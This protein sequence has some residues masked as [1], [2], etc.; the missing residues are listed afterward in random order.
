MK[1]I[2]CGMPSGGS[3]MVYSTLRD[4]FLI[5]DGKK[6]HRNK[7]YG[8]DSGGKSNT[9]NYLYEPEQFF[10]GESWTKLPRGR[11]SKQFETFDEEG[12]ASLPFEH[13]YFDHIINEYENTWELPEQFW[14]ILNSDNFIM[15]QN[16]LTRIL[17][18]LTLPNEIELIFIVRAPLQWSYSV[19]RFVGDIRNHNSCFW[20]SRESNSMGTDNIEQTIDLWIDIAYD[21]IKLCNRRRK[22]L[23]LDY[24][25][26]NNN[27]DNFKQKMDNFYDVD[28]NW[29]NYVDA[30]VKR[31]KTGK[32]QRIQDIPPQVFRYKQYRSQEILHLMESLGY[33]QTQIDLYNKAI[34]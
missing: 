30:P 18:V 21:I 28:M 31:G 26:L 15:K 8:A 25:E 13:L 17:P 32:N 11:Y 5:A 14:N 20:L 9:F 4:S 29:Y 7:A 34:I 22:T 19:S 2:V 12:S 23:F 6:A 3:T 33:N 27:Y 10:K 24:Y 1:T 16:Y